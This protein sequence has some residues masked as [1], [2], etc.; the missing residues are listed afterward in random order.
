VDDLTETIGRSLLKLAG[1][2]LNPVL[3][4]HVSDCSGLYFDGADRKDRRK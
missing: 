4:H 1:G 3:N 2:G